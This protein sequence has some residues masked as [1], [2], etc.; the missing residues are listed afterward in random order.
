MSDED[1]IRWDRRYRGAGVAPLVDD[2][3]PAFGDAADL[4]PHSGVALDV[5]CGRGRSAVWL[6]RRGLEV[7]GVDVSP[8]AIELAQ[9]LAAEA[10]VA[11][12]CEF[13]LVDLDDGLPDTPPLDLVFCHL[14]R[15]ARLDRAMVERIRPGGV[16]AIAALSEVGHGPGRFRMAPGQLREAFGHLDV[17]GEAESDGVGWLIARKR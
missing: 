14:F 16:L 6:A 5:A 8:V 13:A 9:R 10:G 17:L 1:R 3:P 2:P 7:I 11:D 15:D 12:R 4:L